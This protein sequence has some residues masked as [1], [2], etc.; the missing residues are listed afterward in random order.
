[1]A[2]PLFC[3]LRS[4]EQRVSA[5][6]RAVGNKS[7]ISDS[8][9]TTNH[10]DVAPGWTALSRGEGRSAGAGEERSRRRIDGLRRSARF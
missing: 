6:E 2:G 7:S 1:M 8:P 9:S 5:K 4:H 10:G 3:G